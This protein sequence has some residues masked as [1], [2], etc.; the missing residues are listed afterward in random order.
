MRHERSD[1]SSVRANQLLAVLPQMNGTGQRERAVVCL[2]QLQIFYIS[3]SEKSR[4][5]RE[6]SPV[7]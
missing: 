4:K 2:I 7:L 6:N 5:Y 1:R 3:G